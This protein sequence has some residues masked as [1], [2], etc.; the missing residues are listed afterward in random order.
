VPL[1]PIYS[2][3][4]PF[5]ASTILSLKLP[6]DAPISDFVPNLQPVYAGRTIGALLNHSSGLT[7]YG[8]L[9]EYHA[10]VA[11]GE[12]AWTREEL[13]ARCLDMDHNQDGFR[14]SNIGY[15]LL[16]M[17]IENITGKSMFAAFC[18]ASPALARAAAEGSAKEWETPTDVVPGYDPR[19]V[20]S[21]TFLADPAKLSALFSE[22]ISER[23]TL[24]P[25]WAGI[26]PVPY[27]NTGFDTPGYGYGLMTDCGIEGVNPRFV[28]HGGGGPGFSLM[29]LHS[30][31]TA[32]TALKHSTDTNWDQAAVIGELR[33]QLEN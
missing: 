24:A 12:S 8:A 32:Q 21:G 28:G 6:L 15:L 19:W 29:I 23:Q 14:Y 22:L 31:Q 9:P 18:V 7:D 2:I 16:R 30:T 13:L 33:A 10:A 5:L 11:A 27:P 26:Q 25:L 17:A 4:K 20:Y 1:I 3:A